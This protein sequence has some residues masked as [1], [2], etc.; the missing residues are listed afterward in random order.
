MLA[1]LDLFF[2]NINFII[3]IWSTDFFD[4]YGFESIDQSA[5]NWHIIIL[6]LLNPRTHEISLHLFRNWFALSEFFFLFID[7]VCILH[8]VS[9]NY[10][11]L[12]VH[13]YGFVFLISNLPWSLLIWK[14]S[15][16]HINLVYFNLTIIRY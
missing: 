13:V 9:P 4:W 12:L 2:L 11:I 8:K 16:C 5:N 15:N 14:S 3:L 10:F 1:I 6:N 7:Y